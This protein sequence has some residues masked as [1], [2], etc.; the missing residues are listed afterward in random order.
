MPSGTCGS[1]PA[2]EAEDEDTGED[3]DVLIWCPQG[4]HPRPG[5]FENIFPCVYTVGH[6][7]GTELRDTGG[8]FHEVDR[9]FEFY[10]PQV[11]ARRPS[12][13]GPVLLTGWAG[14]ASEDDQ[15]P[16]RPGSGST[17]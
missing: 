2:G 7:V 13:P 1:A 11:F 3:W 8:V 4:I 6:L 15:P 17:P 9:G 16:S 10:A 12:E 14:N 5:G